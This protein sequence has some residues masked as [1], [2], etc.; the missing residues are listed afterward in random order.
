[1]TRA[2]DLEVPTREGWL[3]APSSPGAMSFWIRCVVGVECAKV[4]HVSMV[5]LMYVYVGELRACQ[6]KAQIVGLRSR[7]ALPHPWKMKA[8]ATIEGEEGRERTPIPMRRKSRHTRIVVK[9]S[10][11][12]SPVFGISPSNEV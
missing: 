5:I 11:R 8:L 6:A 3:L 7:K 4:M 2:F 1:M 12:F 9:E 10:L